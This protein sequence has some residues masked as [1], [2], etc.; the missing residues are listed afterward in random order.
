MHKINNTIY[1]ELYLGEKFN[2]QSCAF[3]G[4][5][6]FDYNS[7][8]EKLESIIKDLILNKNVTHFYCGGRGDFDTI[9]TRIMGRIRKEFPTIRYTLVYSYIP[10]ASS[11]IEKQFDDSL[12]LLERNVPP[13]YAILETNKRIVDKVNFIVVGVCRHF[14]GAYKASVYALNKKKHLINIFEDFDIL[15]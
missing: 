3:F 7:Y 6:E 1:N 12:Y 2:M 10:K 5:S 14:G 11:L 15:N 8:T 9:C 4:H 13:K